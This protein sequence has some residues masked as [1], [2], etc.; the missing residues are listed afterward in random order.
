MQRA[1]EFDLRL[2]EARSRSDADVVL[3]H[4]LAD[5]AI[6]TWF[7]VHVAESLS[8]TRGQTGSEAL[9][10][11]FDKALDRCSKEPNK[12]RLQEEYDLIAAC[13]HSLGVREGSKATDAFIAMAEYPN[14]SLS[15]YGIGLLAWDGDDSAWEKILSRLTAML[16]R[17]M[18]RDGL[19]W[20]AIFWA[21]EY[22]TKHAPNGSDRAI[23]LVVLVR[24]KWRRVADPEA[25]EKHW[26]GIGP[27]GP[28]AALVAFPRPSLS[29][30]KRL[31]AAKTRRNMTD[32]EWQPQLRQ[33][34][35]EDS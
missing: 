33:L 14:M 3:A 10:K 7:R 35:S 32:L 23:R 13:A 21:I 15:E 29:D 6:E 1:D 12:R 24:A 2:A 25:L 19:R 11:E 9:R 4:M 8:R 18:N 20:S 28:E 34:T 16:H 22:L 30:I 26:P 27:D 5:P 31:R 17:P